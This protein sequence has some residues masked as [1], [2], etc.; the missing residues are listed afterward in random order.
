MHNCDPGRKI[1]NNR[2]RMRNE[3]VR[4]AEVALQLRKQVYNL[5]ADAH[6]QS[7]NRLVTDDEF[8]A[9][10]QSAGDHDALALAP[11]ELVRIPARR[12]GVEAD[13]TKQFGNF[14]FYGALISILAMNNKRLRY[15]IFDT[16]A[17][18]ERA[19]GI[20]KDNLHVSSQPAQICA[21]HGEQVAAIEHD[22]SSGWL[23]QAQNKPS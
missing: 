6:V 5:R 13:G 23:D 4:E 7:R 16:H 11:A 12:G 3:Q 2:H 21:S 9:E 17:G 10:R 18:I 19:E 20:L 8:R 22:A 15:Q 14:V 1:A